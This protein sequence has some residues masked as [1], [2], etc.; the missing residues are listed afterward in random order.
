MYDV[1][2]TSA[3]DRAYE[4]LPPRLQQKVE[5]Q[6]QRLRTDLKHPSL[7]THRRKDDKNVWQARVTRSYRILF[8]LEGDTITLLKVTAHEK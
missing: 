6:I 2:F 4:K 8:E 7:H 3:F 1:L 5:D